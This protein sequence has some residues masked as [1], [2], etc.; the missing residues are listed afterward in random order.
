MNLS[1]NF[2]MK[3]ILMVRKFYIRKGKVPPIMNKS[4]VD[5]ITLIEKMIFI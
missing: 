2:D 5:N 3:A 4:K 1:K